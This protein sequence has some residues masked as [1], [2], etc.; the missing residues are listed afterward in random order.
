MLKLPMEHPEVN[1]YLKN[2]K[3]SVQLE[4]ANINVD[5][6]I[7]ETTKAHKQQGTGMDSV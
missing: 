4:M 3:M 5:K 2:L 1:E 6:A 7:E